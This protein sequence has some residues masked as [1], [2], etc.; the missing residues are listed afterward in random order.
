MSDSIMAS[1]L[2]SLLQMEFTPPSG[3]CNE[4]LLLLVLLLSFV[5][6]LFTMWNLTHTALTLI[7]KTPT[8]ALAP[9]NTWTPF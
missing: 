6:C 9:R 1:R 4:L 7:L 5:L 2:R 8:E 3:L